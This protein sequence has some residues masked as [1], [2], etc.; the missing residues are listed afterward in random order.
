MLA[1]AG[2]GRRVAAV[3][4]RVAP[5]LQDMAEPCSWPNR[6]SARGVVPAIM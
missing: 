6:R 2:S 4:R 3:H 1:Q 5:E